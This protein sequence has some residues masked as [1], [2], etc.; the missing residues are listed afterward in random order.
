MGWMHD[1]LAYFSHEPIHR[2]FHHSML[3][4]RMLYGF[5]ENF[6]LPLSHDEVV[7]GKGSLVGKMPGDE[8]Q[9]F[10]NLRLLFAYMFAQPGKKLLFMGDEF[11]QVREWAHDTSL[12]WHVLQ[13]PVHSGLQNWVEQLN[14]LYRQE[15]ALHELD[16]DH[17]GFEW[18]DF[19]DNAAST[20]SLVR[21]PKSST[22]SIVIVC[23]FTPVPRVGYRLGVPRGGYWRELL[24]SDGREYGG[25]GMGNM[26]GSMAEERPAHGRPYS[27]NLTLPPLAA[28]FLKAD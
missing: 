4:F 24:N 13:Y 8:W 10:A 20:I 18:I 1:T 22:D 26:G 12:E 28:L 7:H 3:T 9:K 15:P 23:N 27:L 11:G 19:N 17:R 2:Q 5:T 14:R 21:K 6:V 25:S 16:N